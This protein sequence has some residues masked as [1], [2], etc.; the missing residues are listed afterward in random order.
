MKNLALISAEVRRI[1]SIEY[2]KYTSC[3]LYYDI[4]FDRFINLIDQGNIMIDIRLGTYRSGK[5]I[6]KLHDHGTGFRIK[7]QDIHCLY[8]NIETI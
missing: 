6:G 1:D 4:S 7:K 5:N 2:F 3:T 8:S